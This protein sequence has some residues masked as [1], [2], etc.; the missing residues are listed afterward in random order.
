MVVSA[1]E[2]SKM[3]RFLF[4]ILFVAGRAWG[5]PADK[6][7]SSQDNTPATGS[8][9]EYAESCQARLFAW[10]KSSTSFGSEYGHT[11]TS[12]F[13][14]EM[15]VVSHE[16]E[17]P[18]VTSM[19]TLCDGHPR[20]VGQWT[21]H[22]GSSTTYN[23]QWT[24]SNPTFI[25][26]PYPTP[27]PCSISP[28]DCSLLYSSWTSHWNSL[29]K[30]SPDYSE[31]LLDPPCTTHE[32]PEPSYSTNAQGK[33][34]D[35]C[36]IA[37]HQIRL[38]YW[39]V[40]TYDGSGDLCGKTAETVTA[41]PTGP[42]R[43]I[44]TE[45]ITITSPTV[46]ISIADL[47]RVDDCGT[48][49]KSTIIPVLPEA[50]SSVEGARAL[51]THRPFNFADLNYKCLD[52]P[53]KDF[54]TT[55]TRTDCYREVPA[56]AY[57]F[58]HANAAG[59]DWAM[60]GAFDNRTIWPNY[61]PQVLPP[62]TLTDAIRSLWGAD[63]NI[64]PDGIWDP[65][66]ALQQENSFALPE[67]VPGAPTQ[68]YTPHTDAPQPGP[69]TP[70]VPGP[71]TPVAD[72]TAEEQNLPTTKS[73]PRPTHDSGH[74]HEGGWHSGRPEQQGD[75]EQH[76]GGESGHQGGGNGHDAGQGNGSGGDGGGGDHEQAGGEQNAG[77]GSGNGQNAGHGSEQGEGN[78]GGEHTQDH[79]SSQGSGSHQGGNDG[80][81]HAVVHTT[82]ITYT[83]AGEGEQHN[84][85]AQDTQQGH[86]HDTQQDQGH[87]QGKVYT[88]TSVISQSAE[89]DGST[90]SPTRHGH[91]IDNAP[92]RSANGDNDRTS[93]GR[94]SATNPSTTG[95]T[96]D[97]ASSGS[98]SDTESSSGGIS[99]AIASGIGGGNQN[100]QDQNNNPPTQN[101]NAAV[102]IA[103]S[104]RYRMAVLAVLVS[105]FL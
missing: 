26:A 51:F 36:Q 38:L 92:T 54:V 66:I 34:C 94:S 55:G 42:P 43:T 81:G 84:T 91:N 86:G 13:S 95:S 27:K 105:Y 67:Y 79:D 50:V 82:I 40:T 98:S 93:T 16:P 23:Y 85:A 104:V 35:N 96:E 103:K 76:H 21:T 77:H 7:G 17:T 89:Q 90:D 12:I 97:G 49:V 70:N 30:A 28:D 83:S 46:G 56:S 45:G 87:G 39:P 24:N 19:I 53:D 37:G 60:P 15:S 100:G 64:H 14:S 47:S 44:V 102:S 18:T 52:D 29:T 63:C 9:L 59:V 20:V 62:Q 71:T 75:V 1:W 57:F 72:P 3:Q 33:Q 48:T 5:A 10:R 2:V 65:P 41:D 69:T 31:G 73:G 6:N 25:M 61:Q 22:N 11:S 99:S 4:G 8:G 88:V 101:A 58:G 68:Y 80:S 78:Q 74:G 32:R